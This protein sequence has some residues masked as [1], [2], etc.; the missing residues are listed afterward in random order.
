MDWLLKRSR[1]ESVQEIAGSLTQSIIS[2]AHRA[3]LYHFYIRKYGFGYTALTNRL[4]KIL[5]TAP[6]VK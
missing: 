4:S 5:P 2:E 6:G 3:R 1:K